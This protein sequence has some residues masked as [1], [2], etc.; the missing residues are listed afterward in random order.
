MAFECC[1]EK[2]KK[3]TGN[4]NKIRKIFT[5]IF[6]CKTP[7]DREIAD[8]LKSFDD[9]IKEETLRLDLEEQQKMKKLKAK[10]F[11]RLQSDRQ[12]YNFFPWTNDNLADF[13]C[14]F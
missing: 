2:S 8:M 10:E 6:S 3:E 4:W 9:L 7:L 14:Q 13:K 11:E 12:N 1:A 5:Q